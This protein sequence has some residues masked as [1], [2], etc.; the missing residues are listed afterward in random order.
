MTKELQQKMQELAV[1]FIAEHYE[2]KK[3]ELNDK[4]IQDFIKG[5]VLLFKKGAAA[6]YAE[7][8]PLVEWIDV[9]ERLPEK[10]GNYLVKLQD[11]HCEVI[12]YCVEHKYFMYSS[13]IVTHWRKIEL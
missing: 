6:M 8:A 11:G 3:E 7:L 12:S 2:F 10:D 9:N 5:L 1:K 4:E 13:N